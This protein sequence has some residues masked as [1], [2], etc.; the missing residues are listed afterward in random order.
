LEAVFVGL[1]IIMGLS[2]WAFVLVGESRRVA[3]EE[4]QRQ[5]AMLMDEVDAH[6]RTDA[7]LQKAK[8]V[9]ESANVAKTRFIAG[10][11][12]EIRTPLNSINGYAQLLERKATRQPEEAVRVI[13]RS[14]E[15]ITNL[16]DGL[17]DISKIETGSL[18]LNRDTVRIGDFLD[19]LVDMFRLQAEAKGIGFRYSRSPSLPPYVS[20]DQKRVGQ[21]LLNLLSNAIKYTE[22]GHVAFDVRYRNDIAE[23]SITD[24]G[25]GIAPDEIERVFEPFERGRSA[26]GRVPGTGLGLTIAKLL[27]QIL[28]GDLNVTSQLGRGSNF[29]V[30]L[31]M[32]RA[33][34][35]EAGPT[36]RTIQ[37]YRGQ[38]DTGDH[39]T[40]L[41]VDDD[42]SH[43][44]FVEEILTP[45]GFTVFVAAEGTECLELAARCNPDLVMMDIS[46]PGM[47]G[48]EVARALREKGMDDLAIMMVSA[49]AQEFGAHSASPGG[50]LDQPHDDY[51]IKPFELH[52]MFE[53]IQTL[54]DIDWVCDIAPGEPGG[55]AVAIPPDLPR[56]HI[57]ALRQLGDIGHMHGIE[58]K[59]TEIETE[60]PASAAFLAQLRSHARG[61]DFAR[62]RDALGE[63]PEDAE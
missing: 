34:P 53:R 48:W 38:G 52:E 2:A 29:R 46:M 62:F 9:A 61:F 12:H 56:R 45:L 43:S 60:H 47:S 15:H 8:E 14:A 13:R 22:Q 19:Q 35:K 50:A 63:V 10:L 51:L 3:E 5:T 28:G 39:R 27:T 7:A 37:G 44:G 31:M 17:L 49:E 23:F 18:K 41:V 58:A 32:S 54:L 11:S 42:P 59:L 21:I 4:T 26:A 1:S 20:T 57:D 25:I 36:E 33:Q 40:I 55:V 30:R 16:L 6:T 24:S